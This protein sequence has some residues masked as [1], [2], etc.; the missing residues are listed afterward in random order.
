MNSSSMLER[1]Y[2]LGI[3][4]EVNVAQTSVCLL[5][6]SGEPRDGEE[7]MEA[8]PRPAEYSEWW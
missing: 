5:Y 4:A 7:D 2:G 8:R 3:D 1:A 6:E